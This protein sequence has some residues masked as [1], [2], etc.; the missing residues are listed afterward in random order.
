MEDLI[1]F[2]AEQTIL[3]SIILNN[4]KIFQVDNLD[5]KFFA[6]EAHGKLFDHLCKVI[7]IED[8]RQD[9]VTLKTY[10]A[11][12]YSMKELGG[13]DYLKNLLEI[14]GLNSVFT[15][16]KSYAK[17]IIDLWQK[18]EALEAIKNIDKGKTLEEIKNDLWLKFEA[19]E[20]VHQ[21]EAVLVEKLAND[22]IERKV[23]NKQ[24]DDIISSGYKSI[25]DI[26]GGFYGGNLIILAGKTSMGKTSLGLNIAKQSSKTN[27]VLYHSIEM[28]DDEVLNRFISEESSVNPYRLKSAQL[29]P[30]ED[31]TLL[32]KKDKL[33]KYK[34]LL[35]KSGAINLTRLNAVVKKAV[36]KHNIKLLVVDYLGRMTPLNTHEGRERQIAGLT[37][38][39][40][41]IAQKYNIAVLALSQL[42]R[43]NEKRNNK[44]PILSDLRDSGSIEQDADIVM[45]V[46]RDDYYLEKEKED[47]SSPRYEKWQEALNAVKGKAE[48]LIQKNRNGM[49]GSV[50][51]YFDKEFTRFVEVA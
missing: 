36:D 13:V 15:P 4:D 26:T 50:Q 12:E 42:S 10:F 41:N 9:A 21:S 34:L 44:R 6:I 47:P 33:G 31:Q 38:G 16:L 32:E 46:H 20:V 14:A 30:I 27:G 43:E 18:R 40:K 45:F 23:I 1:N 19:L 39:L 24:V 29:K 3:G 35:N 48:I 28:S 51:M 37:D 49:T 22:Y 5:G 8:F 25:D 11:E 7:A 17:I 2:E